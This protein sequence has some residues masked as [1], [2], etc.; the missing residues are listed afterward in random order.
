MTYKLKFLPIALKEWK[1][2]GEVIK[3][4]FKKKL[5]ERLENPRIASAALSGLKDHYK[6]KLRNSGYRLVYKVE[7][8]EICII[9]VAVAKRDKGYVYS[10]VD[11][12]K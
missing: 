11:K 10:L 7:D 5:Q 3:S 2:L 1:K 8:K 4:Q 9:V 6:I 12:R